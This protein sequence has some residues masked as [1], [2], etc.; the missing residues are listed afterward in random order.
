MGR[1]ILQPVKGKGVPGRIPFPMQFYEHILFSRPSVI[2]ND[3]SIEVFDEEI[4]SWDMLYN[5]MSDNRE[6]FY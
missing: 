3:V 6:M 5:S 4:Y 2:T 1:D